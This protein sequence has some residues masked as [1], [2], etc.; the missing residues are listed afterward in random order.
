MYLSLNE[1]SILLKQGEVVALPTETVYGV[2]ASIHHP[3]AIQRIFDLKNRPSNNP[4]IVHIASFEQLYP[5]VSSLPPKSEQLARAFWPGPLTLIFPIQSQSLNPIITAGLITAAFR[6]PCHSLTQQVIQQVGPLVM[7]SANLSGRP[8]STSPQHVEEDFGP[9]FPILDGGDC[10]QGVESTI[11]CY[12]R[13]RWKIAR[14]GALPPEAFLPLLGY[15]PSFLI[16]NKEEAPLCPGQHYRHYAPHCYLILTM[17]FIEESDGLILGF[18]DREYPSNYTIWHFGD[19][20]HP[21]TA[22]QQLYRLLRQ[23]DREKIKE[24][25]VDVRFPEEGLWLT[26]KERLQRAAQK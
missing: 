12:Y 11:L 25:Y 3:K 2:A 6:M 20:S 17:N 26:L 24:A 16:K 5:L 22:L 15:S 13:D 4:L 1:A 10:K 19:S 7:P 8:S 23:L 21:E 18:S 14:A 9:S